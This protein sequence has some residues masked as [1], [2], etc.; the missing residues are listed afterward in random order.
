MTNQSKELIKIGDKVWLFDINRRVYSKDGGIGRA[1]IY[2]EHFYEAII[3]GETKRSWIVNGKK[4]DKKD[5]RGLYTNKQKEDAIWANEN[6]RKIVR[7]VE[8]CNVSLLRRI[9]EILISGGLS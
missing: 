2:S 6:R 1:P 9:Q 5:C 3:S 8:I 7:K 4:F